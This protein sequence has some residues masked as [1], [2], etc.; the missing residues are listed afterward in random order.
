MQA[1]SE[2]YSA[3]GRLILRLQL[4]V[5][6]RNLRNKQRKQRSTVHSGICLLDHK[7]RH[8]A[9]LQAHSIALKIRFIRLHMGW[10]KACRS[11]D[12]ASTVLCGPY[13]LDSMHARFSHINAATHQSCS[14]KL[15]LLQCGN[16]QTL[17]CY[18]MCYLVSLL[19]SMISTHC[20]RLNCCV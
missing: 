14:Q 16:H 12:T 15:T 6:K 10:D 8:I 11:A 19:N 18:R 17:L 9:I 13:Q 1:V 4:S 5:C 3:P 20:C 7:L 2:R